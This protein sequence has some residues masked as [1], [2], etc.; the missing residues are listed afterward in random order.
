MAKDYLRLLKENFGPGFDALLVLY[1][2]VLTA[3]DPLKTLIEAPAFTGSVEVAAKQIVSLWMLSQYRIE[4]SG[5]TIDLD[6]G[7]YEKGFA[8][9]TIQAHP[10]GFSHRSYGYWATK[11]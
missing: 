2:S 11:P 3:G 4:E 5:K 1:R 7:F 10:I 6:G 8:W 9:P